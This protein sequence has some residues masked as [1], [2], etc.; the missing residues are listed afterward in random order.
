MIRRLP[1]R[2]L[3]A[4][5]AG[6][7]I[8]L[9]GLAATSGSAASAEAAPGAAVPPASAGAQA[10]PGPT[11][12]SA[13]PAGTSR[14]GRAL[15]LREGQTLAGGRAEGGAE[16]PLERAAGGDTP[17]LPFE[18][19]FSDGDRAAPRAVRLLLDTG[20]ASTMVTPQLAERLGLTTRPLA[21]GS[22]ALAG[23]GAGCAQLRPQRTR[24]PDLVLGRGGPNRLRLRGVE[25]LVLPVAALPPGLDGVLG[26]PSLRQLP[27][28]IDPIA[29]RL[30]LGPGAATPSSAHRQPTA[31]PHHPHP[32]RTGALTVPLRWQQGVPLVGLRRDGARVEA[33]ADSGAE[34]LFLSPTLAAQ[35]QPVGPAEA[36]RLV[37]VCGE[38]R[39]ERRR[40]R[41]LSL[42]GGA[43]RPATGTGSGAG[44]GIGTMAAT[45]GTA[46][47]T[48]TASGTGTMA[49]TGTATATVEGI[50]T[51]NP[52]FAALGV[53]AIAGQEW[54]RQHRQ[55]WRL[56]L[57]P[58]QLLLLP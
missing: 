27:I 26:A 29:A 6:G 40:F 51:D 9:L 44:K 35:L 19:S 30:V 52:V 13:L 4:G 23:G 46:T 57:E 28:L 21:P 16:L 11:A 7:S 41:G 33:L 53:E 17:V 50:V 36:L 39:V 20:A 25:A 5:M 45:T 15:I 54:L 18:A 8:A 38:Q 32:D 58:P 22:L 37:G 48:G 12:P 34:G 24:L 2:C 56:D 42:P 1:N 47:T 31:S 49:A 43:G 55:L 14:Q 3:A 10:E